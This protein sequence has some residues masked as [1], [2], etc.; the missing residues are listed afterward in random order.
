MA[1]NDGDF[2]E[3]DY[4]L[5]D[6]ESGSVLATTSEEIAKSKGIYDEHV[7][8][9]PVLVILGA[10]AVVKGLERE[11]KGMNVGESKSVVLQPDEAFGKRDENLIKVMKLSDFKA[12]NINPYP[13]MRIN[14]DNASVTVK[15]VGSG[16]VVVDANHPDAGKRVKYDIKVVRQLSDEKERIG[17]LAKTYNA[18][19]SSIEIG[20]DTA[21]LFYDNKVKKDSDYFV[22]KAS[23]LAAIFSYIKP[24]KRII[25]KEEYVNDFGAAPESGEAK[26]GESGS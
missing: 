5:W 24:V 14:I 23:S 11:L 15:S 26:S 3:V 2:L 22:S 7:T 20:G 25:V 19:P 4:T 10:N 8:Y 16:R 13:G 18:K 17:A 9:E 12:Q 21:E 1:F 6:G